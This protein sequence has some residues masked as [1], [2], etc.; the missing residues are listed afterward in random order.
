MKFKEIIFIFLSSLILP[1][2]M[3]YIGLSHNAMQE[4]C[5]NDPEHSGNCIIN[6]ESITLLFF[7]WF[8]FS[9]LVVLVFFYLV[10]WIKLKI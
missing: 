6:I 9:F 8:I 5:I 7:L 4:F 1:S 2:V 10:K 3:V